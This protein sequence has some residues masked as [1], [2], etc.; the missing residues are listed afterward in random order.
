MGKYIVLSDSTKKRSAEESARNFGAHWARLGNQTVVW[1][2]SEEW[3]AF[4]NK[5]RQAGI[6][7]DQQEGAELEGQP[8]LVIQTGRSFLDTY[9]D[10]RIVIDKGRYLV[11]DLLPEEVCTPFF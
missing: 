7:L 11:V 1:T 4:T 5:A 10:V 8:Y 9:P 6:N 3:N 2:A